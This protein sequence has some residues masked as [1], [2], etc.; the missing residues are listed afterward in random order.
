MS[1]RSFKYNGDVREVLSRVPYRWLATGTYGA[2]LIH[3]NNLRTHVFMLYVKTRD[4]PDFAKYLYSQGAYKTP[5]IP[6]IRLLVV[7]KLPAPSRLD[8]RVVNEK[9]LIEDLE[10]RVGARFVENYRHIID[11]TKAKH[12]ARRVRLRVSRRKPVTT[13]Q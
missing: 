7:D 9:K 8:E 12:R 5:I 10:T 13:T 4:L 6:N 1:N 3:D 2:E 11:A